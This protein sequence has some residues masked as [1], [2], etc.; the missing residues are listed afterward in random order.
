MDNIILWI[1]VALVCIWVAHGDVADDTSADLDV[2]EK[3]Q[4]GGVV[5]G[6]V[7]IMVH[8]CELLEYNDCYIEL[9]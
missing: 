1:R 7:Y 3:L 2:C 6:A 9:D 5:L 8:I 4:S